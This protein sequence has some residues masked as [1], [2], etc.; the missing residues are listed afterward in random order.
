MTEQRIKLRLGDWADRCDHPGVAGLPRMWAAVTVPERAGWVN[1]ALHR[2]GSR[3]DT[4]IPAS[5]SVDD[6]DGDLAALAEAAIAYAN[7]T[8]YETCAERYRGLPAGLAG[9]CRAQLEW[10]ARRL[11]LLRPRPW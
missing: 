4:C 8:P 10:S 7:E 9:A 6:P 5:W 2:F 11:P 3:W 1:L